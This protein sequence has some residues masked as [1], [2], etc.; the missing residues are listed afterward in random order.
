MD[1]LGTNWKEHVDK[2]VKNANPS[3]YAIN[4]FK[5]LLISRSEKFD[6]II[7]FFKTSLRL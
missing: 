3:L 7:L 4:H 1:I 2:T 6:N 5:I